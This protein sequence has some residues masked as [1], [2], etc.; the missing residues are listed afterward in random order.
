MTTMTTAQ[1][2]TKLGISIRT[3]Q[4]R[5]AT[6]KLSAHK[7]ARGRWTITMEDA[8]TLPQLTGPAD[9]LIR[10][11]ERDRAAALD[12]ITA[13]VTEAAGDAPA[14]LVTEVAALYREVALRHTDAGW[15]SS[16]EGRHLGRLL[17][18]E[19]TADDKARLIALAAR[20]AA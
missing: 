1:A 20:R 17:Q 18:W 14:N 12:R 9:Y 6:G 19:F 8:M 3:A 2:A 15:W 7:D 16:T 13:E 10:A 4:R 5:C 11:A